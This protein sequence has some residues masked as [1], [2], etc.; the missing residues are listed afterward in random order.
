MKFPWTIL[1]VVSIL[2]IT[3]GVKA[4]PHSGFGAAYAPAAPPIPE[5][6][7]DERL[8]QL[9]LPFEVQNTPQV[10]SFIRRYFVEGYRDAEDLLGLTTIYFPIFEHYL[11]LYNLPEELKYLPLIESTL[12]P[13]ITSPAGA[14]GLW[15][16]VPA[17][18]RHYGLI[19]NGTIDERLDPHKATE[20]AVRMLA[21]L[22]QQF[23][24]WGLALAAYNCGPGRVQQALRNASCED[25]WDVQNYLP[26]ESQRYV[27]GFIAAAYLVNYYN[28][29]GLAP[30]YPDYDLQDTRTFRVY[31]RL[32]LPQVAQQLGVD[33]RLL[34]QL[35][36]AYLQ[37][38]VP[39][40]NQGHFVTVPARVAPAFMERYGTAGDFSGTGG[41]LRT[42]Y[43]VVSGDQIETLA[44]LFQCTPEDIMRWNGLQKKEV[45]VN[46]PLTVFL[47]RGNARP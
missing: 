2:L 16:F 31:S 12:R 21:A 36:P 18:A 14:A 7:I 17:T 37:G 42:T 44:L 9:Q 40:S 41:R 6:Q 23:G 35:N 4:N 24:D 10:Q 13:R 33:Y 19:I 47:P 29:H 34:Y 3:V 5:S 32:S 30:D 38:V 1:A 46:Q 45:V 27:P 15:Q 26:R 28:L 20:A 11:R 43:T 22:Y 39:G 25:F 8:A